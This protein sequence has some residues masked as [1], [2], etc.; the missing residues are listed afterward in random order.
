M[1]TQIHLATLGI[2]LGI[3]SCSTPSGVTMR[4]Y[5]AMNKPTESAPFPETLTLSVK[6]PR[7]PVKTYPTFKIAPDK[8]ITIE[9][10]REF[11]YPSA[12][13][14]AEISPNGMVATPATPE[15]FQKD[16][17]GLT[18][19][20]T[21]KRMGSLVLIE[22]L[23]S[24]KEFA[25]FSRMGGELGEPILDDRGR[26]VTENRIEMPKFETFST[27]VYVAVRPGTPSEFEIGHPTRGTKVTV[28]VGH[29]E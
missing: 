8:G 16:Y 4:D 25:G 22:G 24:V 20:L 13:D 10:G 28:V 29:K 27:P 6:E 14:P 2:A 7:K 15:K 1:K 3:F 18:A 12:Y 23:I 17:T 19:K 9:D 11:I 26:V 21:T 5:S